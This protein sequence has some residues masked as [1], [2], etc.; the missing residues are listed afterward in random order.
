ML[1][2]F[3]INKTIAAVAYLVQKENGE[4]NVFLALKTLWLADEVALVQ[5]GKRITGDSFVRDKGPVWPDSSTTYNLFKG[6]G[7]T[8]EQALWNACVSE[9][10]NHKVGLLR[11]VDLGVL[12]EH[13]IETLN[14]ALIQMKLLSS[15]PI[16]SNN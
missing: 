15:R 5:L 7:P 6:Q 9:R 3:D 8:E 1:L 13:E 11:N 14:S 2:D 10:V 16:I 4:L 12:S